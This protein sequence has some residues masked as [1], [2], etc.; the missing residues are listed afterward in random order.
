MFL[1]YRRRRIDIKNDDNEL[2]SSTIR[3]YFRSEGRT[4]SID[5]AIYT[6]KMILPDDINTID[7]TTH[8]VSEDTK[9]LVIQSLKR[10]IPHLKT[11]LQQQIYDIIHRLEHNMWSTDTYYLLYN[12]HQLLSSNS[13][14]DDNKAPLAPA[15]TP[16]NSAYN[17]TSTIHTAPIYIST[18]SFIKPL[19]HSIKNIIPVLETINEYGQPLQIYR[20]AFYNDIKDAKKNS[21]DVNIW[22]Y[23]YYIQHKDDRYDMIYNA[24][25]MFSGV[26]YTGTT[27]YY[28]IFQNTVLY[29]TVLHKPSYDTYINTINTLFLNNEYGYMISDNTLYIVSKDDYSTYKNNTEYVLGRF[30]TAFLEGVYKV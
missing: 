26:L 21:Y 6:L 24:L 2:L 22:L 20:N 15:N 5:T 23:N 7:T 1:Y 9:T 19:E 25:F 10:I 17:D 29:A 12:M 11:Q 28:D 3:D 8:T 27:S 14:N 4:S 16:I 30:C 18:A 13:Y